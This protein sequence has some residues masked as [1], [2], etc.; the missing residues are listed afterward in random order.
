MTENGQPRRRGRQP[1]DPERG[2]LSGAERNRELRGRAVHELRSLASDWFSLLDLLVKHSLS[3]VLGVL[4]DDN[5]PRAVRRIL[6]ATEFA[7]RDAKLSASLLAAGLSPRDVNP[8]FVP[9]LDAREARRATKSVTGRKP[10]KIA[11]SSPLD[12]EESPPLPFP[13]G[14]EE[15]PRQKIVTRRKPEKVASR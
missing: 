2:A 10:R 13:V 5:A 11:P 15:Q 14:Q 12:E 4:S 8:A 6:G 1:K 9:L 7:S 3:T